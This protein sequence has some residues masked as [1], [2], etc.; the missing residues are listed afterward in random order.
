M[1]IPGQNKPEQFVLSESVTKKL[2]KIN[3]VSEILG[4]PIS[5]AYE[6]TR[7]N[8]I[9]G[10]IRVG[11]HIRFDEAKFMARLEAGGEKQ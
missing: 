5:T 9:G 8:R 2:I 6:L 4:I 11:R 3:A 7:Q 10:L 1:S